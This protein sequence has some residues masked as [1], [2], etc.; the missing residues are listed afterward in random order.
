MVGAPFRKYPSL[1]ITP[2]RPFPFASIERHY[3]Q[4]LWPSQGP[5]DKKAGW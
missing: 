3:A 1:R 4:P 5:H 2:M